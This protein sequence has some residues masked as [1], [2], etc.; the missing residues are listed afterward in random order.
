M[1]IVELATI[2]KEGIAEQYTSKQI[3]ESLK[4]LGY[5]EI[6]TKKADR[7]EM[8]WNEVQSLSEMGSGVGRDT[9]EE[10]EGT[11]ED[12]TRKDKTTQVS[13]GIV[14]LVHEI[15]GEIEENPLTAEYSKVK[16]DLTDLYGADFPVELYSEKYEDWKVNGETA[17][18]FENK[19]LNIVLKN[20]FAV[21]NQ[22][23]TKKGK[24][25]FTTL[26]RAIVRKF[27]FDNH[28]TIKT[29]EDL[30]KAGYLT[31]ENITDATEKKVVEALG[32]IL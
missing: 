11:S 8:F 25:S 9:I 19:Y 10:I 29:N 30:W 6:P 17:L 5:E 1:D 22:K 13:T 31:K 14:P 24:A 21:I 28:P 7:V 3:Q 27:I 18:D 4:D 23:K 26:V 32:K 12:E 16:Q 2:G 20:N 15:F